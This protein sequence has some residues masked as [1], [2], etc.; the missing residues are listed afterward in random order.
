ML[1]HLIYN[2]AHLDDVRIQQEISKK[3]YVENFGGAYLTHA[4]NGK[5]NFGYKKYLEDKFIKLNN[6]GHFQGAAD[7]INAGLNFFTKNKIT[8]LD[9]VLVTAADTWLLDVKFLHKLIKE[10][11]EENKILAASS[12]GRSVKPEK[13]TGFSLDFFII[14]INWNRKAK[15]FPLNYEGFVKKFEDF[16]YM[17]YTQPVL[18]SCFQYN[19]QK[20][21]AKN[22]K[23]NEI[24]LQRE[25]SFRRI[26]EREPVHDKNGQRQ[27]SWPKIG[28]YTD[29]RAKEKKEVLLA[30]NI[31]FGKH[32]HKLLKEKDLS[33]YN[34]VS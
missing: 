25:K 8:G 28:L 27:G 7:L 31:D 19:F 34:K 4:Y 32:C 9:Y 15:L 11:K 21:F 10:M 14:D 29:P 20:Y 16:F 3:L 18:E 2:Y 17:L 23:D 30:K 12:W 1:G 26:V 13:P 24:W 22:Y 5:R 6:R 33:Y